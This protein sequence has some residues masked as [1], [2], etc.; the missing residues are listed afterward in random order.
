MRK[1]WPA[2]Y[3]GAKVQLLDG[4]GTKLDMEVAGVYLKATCY[5]NDCKNV[6]HY[7]CPSWS[8]QGG[9]DVGL[10]LRTEC[11]VATECQ[12]PVGHDDDRVCS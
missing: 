9:Q 10:D 12:G 8:S 7:N 2:V 4:C 6:C 1:R 5:L 11:P 3:L